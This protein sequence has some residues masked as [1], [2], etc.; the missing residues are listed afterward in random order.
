MN[1]SIQPPIKQLE[2]ISLQL[3]ERFILPNG[4]PFALINAAH[5]DVVRIDI[6]FKGGRWR[7]SQKLQALFTS[8]MLRE[9][10]VRYTSKEI[11]EKLDYYGAWLELSSSSDYDFV[12]FYSLNKYF[13]PVLDIIE[14]IIKEPLFPEKELDVVIS[15]NVQQFLINQEKVDYLSQ[16]NIL[17]VLFGQN[18]PCGYMIDES[19]YRSITASGL[20]EYFGQHYHSNNCAIFASGKATDAMINRLVSV[21]GNDSFGEVQ[22]PSALPFFAVSPADEKHIFIERPESM[23]SSVKIGMHIMDRNHP[24][25]LKFRVLTTLLGGYFGSRLMTNIRE[26][27]GYTYGISAG[28]ISYPH[29]NALMIG[30]E[31]DPSYVEPLIKEVYHE[32]D[33]LKREK[34]SLDELNMVKNYMIGEMCRSY[35]SAFSLSDAWIYT[36]TNQLGDDY[37]DKSL[38]QIL[39]T[40]PD[41]LKRLAEQF[42]CK[43]YLKEVIA[44]KK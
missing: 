18:H 30:T 27:K 23:Q 39:T 8:R 41:D 16:R 20:K 11:S 40:T 6:L 33:R 17:K 31:T 22:P 3:P 24:D 14:S 37:Y 42:M 34:V 13:E 4:I 12:T 44:G 10:T 43:D 21:F 32:I 1:R 9:G 38:S 5:E 15:T 19:N 25:F 35:E 7:Q 29:G 2:Q 36:Y 26:D 28:M